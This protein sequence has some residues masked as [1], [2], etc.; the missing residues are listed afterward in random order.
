M[1][2]DTHE[3]DDFHNTISNDVI[4]SSNIS[5]T[6]AIIR[7]CLKRLKLGK[8]EGV[9]VRSFDTHRFH[10]SIDLLFNTMLVLGFTPEDLLKSSI[11]LIPWIIRL[12]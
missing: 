4:P 3:L 2:T 9:C 10:V 11:I 12:R 8:G 7:Q 1:P 6:P 5:I